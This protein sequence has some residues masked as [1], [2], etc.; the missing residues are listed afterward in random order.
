MKKNKKKKKQR[1]TQNKQHKNYIKNQK[2]KKN[3][4]HTRERVRQFREFV[5]SRARACYNIIRE[6]CMHWEISR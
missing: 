2:E 3:W 1:K 4:L 6:V 5:S